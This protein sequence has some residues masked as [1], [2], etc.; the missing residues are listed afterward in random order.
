MTTTHHPEHLVDRVAMAAMR[1]MLGSAKGSVNGP[2]ARKTFDEIMEQVPA[3]SGVTY[4]AAVISG[5][6]G[7]WCR[8]EDAVVHALVEMA[9]N[10]AAISDRGGWHVN[11]SWRRPL[12]RAGVG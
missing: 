1:L 7:W 11:R 9:T 5:V 3:A 10:R 12:R 4:E 8:P 6:S 2:G